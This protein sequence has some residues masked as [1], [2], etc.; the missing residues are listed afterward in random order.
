M[1]ENVNDLYEKCNFCNKDKD[2]VKKLIVGDNVAICNECVDL[3]GD[4]LREITN[5]TVNPSDIND[6]DPVELKEFLD[7]Y[8]GWARKCKNCT[9]GS[10][11]Q[12]LQ[13]N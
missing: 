13:K 2:T 7:K 4:L 10:S 3:C 12:S 5:A 6:I 1:S 8:R 11:C 9:F